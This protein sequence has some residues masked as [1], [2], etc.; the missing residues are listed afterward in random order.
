MNLAQLP[1]N[2]LARIESFTDPLFMHKFLEMGCTPGEVV[3][4]KKVAPLGDPIAV[5]ISGYELSM[6]KAEAS[7]IVVS[8][9]PNH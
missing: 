2:T 3:S 9:I 4:I 1:L 7:T 8:T 6:R 5:T